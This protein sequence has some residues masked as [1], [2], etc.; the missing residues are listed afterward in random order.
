MKTNV[1]WLEKQKLGED[2]KAEADPY[3][4][5]IVKV[6]EKVVDL[7]EA[8]PADQ[9][10]DANALILEKAQLKPPV[11]C[12]VLLRMYTRDVL[13]SVEFCR[14]RESRAFLP[15]VR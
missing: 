8:I 10:I 13:W 11:I 7:M 9:P 14:G 2:G 6:G 3:V 5:A 4:S 15:R 12:S 1:E